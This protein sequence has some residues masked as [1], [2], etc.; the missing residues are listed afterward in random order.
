MTKSAVVFDIGGEFKRMVV[1]ATEGGILE[2]VQMRTDKDAAAK[3]KAA[4]D[5]LSELLMDLFAASSM[6]GGEA[7]ESTDLDVSSV[8][9][10]MVKV[11]VQSR[12]IPPP[13][14]SIRF[15]LALRTYAP[16]GC[17]VRVVSL[18]TSRKIPTRKNLP[19]FLLS[20]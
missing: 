12:S 6:G 18:T 13:W 14:R 20:R 17:I 5:D 15:R 7:A 3:Y 2:L 10:V 4:L 16:W 11:R 19:L 9:E 1:R 8:A